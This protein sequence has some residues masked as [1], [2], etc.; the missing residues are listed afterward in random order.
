MVAHELSEVDVV[1]L[2]DGREG[3]GDD[4]ANAGPALA[5]RRGF[6]AGAGALALAG[7]DDLEAAVDERVFLEHALAFVHEASVGVL[8]DL[9][10]LVVEADPGRRHHVGVDVV[11][12]ILDGEVLH[13]QVEPLVELLADELQ[14]LRQEEDA[15]PLFEADD[16]WRLVL[17]PHPRSG[18]TSHLFNRIGRAPMAFR[19]REESK[20]AH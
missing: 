1:P 7:D 13:A 17:H 6:T 15:G 14:I 20:P 19:R 16:G 11:E 8:G 18:Q 2:V 5:L 4:Q 12:Q 3:G 9:R 10:R